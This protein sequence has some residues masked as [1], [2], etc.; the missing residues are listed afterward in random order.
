MTS[1]ALDK[2]DYRQALGDRAV[3]NNVPFLA[4]VDAET[5]GALLAFDPWSAQ[6]VYRLFGQLY[7]DRVEALREAHPILPGF[8]D[9]LMTQD[10]HQHPLLGDACCGYQGV[11]CRAAFAEK[12]VNEVKLACLR[13]SLVQFDYCVLERL[14]LRLRAGGVLWR[15]PAAEYSEYPEMRVFDQYGLF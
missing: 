12:C 14:A 7:T 9:I 1:S 15:P 8:A 11:Y 6:S 4:T 10:V 3:L 13:Q 5:A 2:L